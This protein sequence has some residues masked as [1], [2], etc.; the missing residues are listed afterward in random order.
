MNLVTEGEVHQWHPG[1]KPELVKDVRERR[2]RLVA[3]G[4]GFSLLG[5]ESGV[6]AS[7]GQGQDGCLGHGD[8][9]S[10]VAPKIIGR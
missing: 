1:Q 4:M 8:F 9:E 3:V 2:L 6:L 10:Q 5:S 7:W